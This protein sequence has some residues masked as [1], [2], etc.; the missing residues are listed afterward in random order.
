M[1]SQ[2]SRPNIKELMMSRLD[3]NGSRQQSLDDF[4]G[5]FVASIE[6]NRVV[7]VLDLG[8]G[9]GRDYEF[10]RRLFPAIR[11]HGLDIEDSPEVQKRR[12]DELSFFSYDGVNMPFPDQSFDVV[13]AR[14]VL[15][16]VRYP[17]DVVAEVE[18]V[19][20]PG[21][22]FIG[23]VSQLEPYHSYSIFNWSPYAIITVFESHSLSVIG[24]APGIDGITL[25]LRRILGKDLFAPFFRHEGLANHYIEQVLIR[26]SPRERAFEK[27]V[28]AGHISFLATKEPRT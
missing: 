27:L 22:H 17:D 4:V 7:N 1:E 13:F 19:L 24:L 3:H 11:Y 26:R 6:A 23:S 20:R 15:E 18:R 14:Q 10:L 5:T 2:L 21:G 8:C 12:R 25:T 28:T 9:T 16:H